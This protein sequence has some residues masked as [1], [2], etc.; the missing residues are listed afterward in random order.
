LAQSEL[1]AAQTPVSYRA[2]AAAPGVS[3]QIPA[4]PAQ[5]ESTTSPAVA[6]PAR[7]PALAN[8]SAVAM[9]TV[10]VPLMNTAT[11]A[12]P[13]VSPAM[14][15]HVQV[16]SSSIDK[17]RSLLRDGKDLLPSDFVMRFASFQR[18]FELCFV[19][20]LEVNENEVCS[21][22]YTEVFFRLES[23]SCSFSLQQKCFVEFSDGVRQWMPSSQVT[24]DVIPPDVALMG[25]SLICSSHIFYMFFTSFIV[26]FS[27][28]GY[29]PQADLVQ[30]INRELLAKQ[31]T[32]PKV[33]C[34][35]SSFLKVN[36]LHLI[37]DFLPSE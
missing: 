36:E 5:V 24:V 26:G 8:S 22:F 4:V 35:N 29:P 16:D 13:T 31:T 12:L 23:C 21:L 20:L 30:N 2:A 15:A 37:H 11:T 25:T 6:L 7:Q 14:I 3:N 10:P 17:P 27:A 18:N 34:S 1:K 9:P 19:I 32:S 28:Y 33:F